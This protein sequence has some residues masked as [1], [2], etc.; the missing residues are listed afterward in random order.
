MP[1]I[2]FIWEENPRGLAG[3][4]VAWGKVW[5]GPTGRSQKEGSCSDN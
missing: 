2:Q 3:S 4:V 1:Q 5:Q